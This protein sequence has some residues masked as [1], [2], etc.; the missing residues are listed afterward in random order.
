MRAVVHAPHRT[1]VGLTVV[2]GGDVGQHFPGQP[3]VTV[4]VAGGSQFWTIQMSGQAGGRPETR[5]EVAQARWVMVVGG[6]VRVV[7]LE[8]QVAARTKG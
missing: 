6:W 8:G 4:E 2:V 7:V 1:Q 3:T 5:V